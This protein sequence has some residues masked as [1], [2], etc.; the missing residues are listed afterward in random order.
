MKK[1]AIVLL[2]VAFVIGLGN[3]TFGQVQNS[4]V[5]TLTANLNT[6]LFKV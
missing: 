4:E 6:T 2:A 5:I 1:I 3:N